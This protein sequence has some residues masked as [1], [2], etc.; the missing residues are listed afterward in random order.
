MTPRTPR[1]SL[2]SPT[3][4]QW[5]IGH[6]QQEV[7]VSEVGATLR[8]YTVGSVPVIDGFGPQEWCHGSRGQVLAPWPNRLADGR[9]EF[10]DIRAQAALDEPERRNAIHGLVRWMPWTLQTRHQNQLSLRLQLHPQPGYPF[11]L[12]LELEYHVGRDGLTVKTTARS[13]EDGPVPFGLGF[14]PYVTAGPETV[15]GAILQLPA[16]DTLDLD[17]RGL[18]TGTATPV[19]GTD[20]DFTTARFL[21][22]TVLDTAFT[23][24]DRDA[25]GK[26]WASLDAPGGASGAALWM[27]RSFKYLMV[28]TGDTLG[29]LSRRRRAVALEPMTSPPNA[30]RSGTDVIRLEPGR[31]WS[32]S[33]GLVPR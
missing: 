9:Y 26:A 32:A 31:E 33:W 8:S 13:L 22:Q 21:G 30:L 19:A 2:A 11:S 7:V 1:I 10:N 24:L 18:P 17:D 23:T 6:D 29:E 25:D 28:Y 15:D 14:H 12:L 4:Q 27:D 3:G 5:R 20:R 16:H